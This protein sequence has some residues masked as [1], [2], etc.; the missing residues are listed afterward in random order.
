MSKLSGKIPTPPF[1]RIEKDTGEA[2]FGLQQSF[3]FT[4][5]NNTN[6]LN[7]EEMIMLANLSHIEQEPI[8]PPKTESSE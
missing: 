4:N 7:E 8:V 2:V 6:N 5:I 1:S 3:D